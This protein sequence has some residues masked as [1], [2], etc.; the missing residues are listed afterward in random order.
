MLKIG[1]TEV[2]PKKGYIPKTN[3]SVQLIFGNAFGVETR[4]ATVLTI[5][6]RYPYVG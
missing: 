2:L 3:I 6:D 1:L 5:F 4:G